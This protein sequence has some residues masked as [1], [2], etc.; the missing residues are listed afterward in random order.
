MKKYLFVFAFS[1]VFFSTK[2][3]LKVLSSGEVTIPLNKSLWITN[4]TTPGDNGYRLRM[5]NNGSNAFIDYYNNLYFRSGSTSSVS[6][7]TF[8]SAGNVGIKTTTPYTALH[9]VGNSTFTQTTSSITSAA[10]IRGLNTYST[11]TTPDYTWYNNDLTG[12]FHPGGNTIG[13]STGGIERLSINSSGKVGI[14]CSATLGNLQINGIGN[15]NGLS[16]YKGT[17][18]DINIYH[19]SDDNAYITRGNSTNAGIR[20]LNNGHVG[21]NGYASSNYWLYVTGDCRANSWSTYSDSTA[22]TDIN[23]IANSELIKVLR[24]VTYRWKETLSENIDAKACDTCTNSMLESQI[25]PEIKDNRMHYGFL[26]QEVKEIFPDVVTSDER[27]LLAIDYDAFIPMLVDCIKKMDIQIDDLQQIVA[28]QQSEI[29]QLMN[30]NEDA[31]KSY[32]SN[33]T[34]LNSGSVLYQNSPNPFSESTIIRYNVPVVQSMAMINV[35][36][37]Q[38]KQIESYKIAQSGSGEVKIAASSLVPGVYIYNLIVDG[39]EVAAK[40]MILTE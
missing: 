4:S 40:R 38:G 28:M 34:Q 6:T 35:Y 7:V 2:A 17:G 10:Y 5:L 21:I 22:K 18:T 26:A 11:A 13:F 36:D 12:I 16:I 9:V 27:G 25:I 19:N 31:K 23:A 29:Q 14:N 20:L 32:S 37:L 1:L 24:P 15:P 8:T 33:E 39:N 3:Q 30:L